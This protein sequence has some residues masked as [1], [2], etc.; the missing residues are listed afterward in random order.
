MFPRL[1]YDSLPG[2]QLELTS[3]KHMAM[4]RVDTTIGGISSGK[5]QGVGLGEAANN[6][7]DNSFYFHSY[8]QNLKIHVKFNG[9]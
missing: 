8:N 2:V 6:V 4:W 1:S 7:C 9:Q 5:K 3:L